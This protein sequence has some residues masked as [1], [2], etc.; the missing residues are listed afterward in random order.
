MTHPAQDVQAGFG[1]PTCQQFTRYTTGVLALFREALPKG[2]LPCGS[3]TGHT[4]TNRVSRDMAVP[5]FTSDSPT[6]GG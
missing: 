6:D 3:G 1:V 2:N 5:G 4:R